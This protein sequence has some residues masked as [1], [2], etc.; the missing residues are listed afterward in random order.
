MFRH[1]RNR[2][3]KNQMNLDS[4]IDIVESDSEV[5]R[6]AFVA[7]E[8]AGRLIENGNLEAAVEHN[9]KAAS[10]AAKFMGDPECD[11]LFLSVSLSLSD[12]CAN[13]RKR[14]DEVLQVLH[15]ARDVSRR[16][17][18]ERHLALLNLH[19]GRIYNL[20]NKSG[21]AVSFFNSGLTVVKE[22]GDDDIRMQSAEF[23]GIF[24]F[25][26]G[27]PN[28]ALEH[29]DRA[30]SSA[31]TCRDGRLFNRMIP[32]IL[33]S[34]AAFSAQFSRAIGV[35]DS[36][37]RRALLKS[38]DLFETWYRAHL[39]NVLLMAGKRPEAFA[40]LQEAHKEARM[41]SNAYALAWAQR[42]LAYYYSLEGRSEKSYDIFKKCLIESSKLGLKKPPYALPW[43]LELLFEY[44]ER[45]YRPLPA[46]DFQKEMEIALH[47]INVHLRG[48]AFRILAKQAEAEISGEDLGKIE[49][50]LKKSETDL[51]C[52]GT[53]V[54]L[55]KT[56]AELAKLR[57][58]QG[59]REEAIEL[60]LQAW[61]GLSIYGLES[62]PKELRSLI[63]GRNYT[64]KGLGEG[65]DVLKRYMEML[66]DLVPSADL[67]ELFFRLLAVTS[68]FFEAERGA[69]FLTEGDEPKSKL[70]LGTTY[71]MAPKEMRDEEFRTNMTY[72]L[73][74]YKNNQSF[75]VKRPSSGYANPEH[76]TTAI[77][78]IPV[79]INGQV[80]GVLYHENI[81]SEGTF[82][83][84]NSTL[85]RIGQSLGI[86]VMRIQQ[87][88]RQ[89]EEKTL[90]ALRETTHKE[91]ADEKEILGQS[92]VIRE[93][94]IRADK[95]AKSDAP[96]LL[97][98]E[99]GVG[100]ELVSRRLHCMSSRKMGPFVAVDLSSIPETL[101]ESELFGHEKGA[102]TGA[103]HQKP[104]RIELSNKGTLFIDEIG[105]ISL[106]LQV[107]L[108]RTLEE[109]TF[110]RLGG[111]KNINS[112][113]RLVAATNRDL[114]KEVEKGNFR[115][116][117]Y[118]RLNV[119]PLI[120]PPLRKRGNDIVILA[121]HFLGRLSK[122]YKQP[123][124]KLTSEIQSVLKTYQ[125]PGNVRELQNV[126]ERAVILGDVEDLKLMVLHGPRGTPATSDMLDNLLSEMPTMDELQRRYITYVIKRT[127]G[128]MSGTGGATEL[129]G[130]KRT[131]LYTRMKKLGVSSEDR[132][133]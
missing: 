47:G 130:M 67:D 10:Y 49:Q 69:I 38:D 133:L 2:D 12:L 60:A 99:T 93:L 125:W 115:E 79:E 21:D 37:W 11:R 24:H 75:N 9:F 45:G 84:S 65:D 30:M 73:R 53:P 23:L 61:E 39:G 91:E 81:Y 78:C 44:H 71:N 89:M 19:L 20:L 122:K 22:L 56:R 80:R 40:H 63:Y 42:A 116:D 32:I 62:F 97:L 7:F 114:V 4:Q 77:L 117:L 3:L 107:K 8:C 68:R 118:Y 57:L 1:V 86:Y 132:H 25:I 55:A 6:A 98:G 127:N 41:R 27:R 108:L 70:I 101:V 121:K 87:Y 104:G 94:L 13:V 64:A 58:H 83:F 123:C 90:V 96:V 72:V 92:P 66:D 82:E 31:D 129:L 76:Q 112:D 85:K 88:C 119:V 46:Y 52:A 103:T 59:H 106:S 5:K 35:M 26:H 113:F 111:V 54:D 17:G 105:E 95:A 50:L 131:T 120:I 109:K 110:Y 48:T 14:K 124:P 29:F 15:Q 74:A 36:S 43:V 28:L 102:F 34:C 16:R 18:D 100:K 126:I 128:K 51:E 33:G